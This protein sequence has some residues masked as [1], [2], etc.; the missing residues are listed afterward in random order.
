MS[1]TGRRPTL[2]DIAAETGLSLAAVSYAL[3][4]L[5][6]TS[7]TR[8]RVQRPVGQWNSLRVVNLN[9]TVTTYING[10]LIA[11]G[12]HSFT[13]PGYVVIQM[14]GGPMRWRNIRI[15]SLD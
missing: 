2:K 9:K 1:G 11:Q 6:G 5:H 7:E 12:T 15:K 3:R 8:Q 13:E 10:A 14:E 4:G